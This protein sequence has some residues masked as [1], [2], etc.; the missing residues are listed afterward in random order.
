[1]KRISMEDLKKLEQISMALEKIPRSEKNRVV[2][3]MRWLVE[4]LRE[5]YLM[6]E[7]EG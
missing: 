1:M 5:A 6:I 3:D 4:K 2:R 7:G